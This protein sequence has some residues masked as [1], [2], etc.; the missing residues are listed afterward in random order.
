[1]RTDPADTHK[2]AGIVDFIRADQTANPDAEEA[3]P[4]DLARKQWLTELAQ[5]GLED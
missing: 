4:T 5:I 3:V 2:R 1:L